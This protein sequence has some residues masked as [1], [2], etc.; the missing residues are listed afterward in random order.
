[1]SQ[2]VCKCKVAGY[3]CHSL[4][5]NKYIL[6]HKGEQIELET[7]NKM[8]DLGVIF[9]SCLI[10]DQYIREKTNRVCSLLGLIKRN[11]ADLSARAFIHL[12]KA[13]VRPH[14]E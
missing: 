5:A 13:I 6:T 12:S 4:S 3:S 1:V 14:L 8:K 11:F 7:V 2:N 10:F 9:D